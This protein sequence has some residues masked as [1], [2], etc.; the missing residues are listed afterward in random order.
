[1][2]FQS[3]HHCPFLTAVQPVLSVPPTFFFFFFVISFYYFFHV[4]NSFPF[5]TLL[6]LT[7]SAFMVTL[8]DSNYK[9]NANICARSHK[10]GRNHHQP[11]HQSLFYFANATPALRWTLTQALQQQ[12][13][14]QRS[15]KQKCRRRRPFTLMIMYEYMCVCELPCKYESRRTCCYC[16]YCNLRLQRWQLNKLNVECKINRKKRILCR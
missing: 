8:R 9:I 15:H 6:Q 11:W 3:I 1:M 12:Q 16:Y 4:L 13:S 7:A 10:G 14:M 5:F 2:C